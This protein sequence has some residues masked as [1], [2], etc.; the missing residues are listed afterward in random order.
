MRRIKKEKLKVIVRFLLVFILWIL[1]GGAKKVFAENSGLKGRVVDTTG[2]ALPYVTI[3]LL[4][5]G[6]S[7]LSY[8][9][10]STLQ[11][12][13]EL[14]NIAAGD[15]VLQ[16]ASVGFN[17]IYRRIHFPVAE[18]EQ[19]PVFV[20]RIRT[21]NLKAAEINAERI[22]IRLKKDTIEYDEESPGL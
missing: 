4:Q 13:F 6:D 21:V 15:Y 22:P 20:L 12:T 17:S 5:P 9:A 14:S 7:T 2:S 8:F 1:S 19:D 16:V 10:V 18:Q 11:G 3:T